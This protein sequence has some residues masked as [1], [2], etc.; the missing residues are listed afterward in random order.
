MGIG[1]SALHTADSTS[2]ADEET[3]SIDDVDRRLDLIAAVRGGGAAARRA[4]ALARLVLTRHS[5]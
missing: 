2:A 5:G 1:Y 4:E 3:L